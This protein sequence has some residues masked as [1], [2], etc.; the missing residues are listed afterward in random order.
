MAKSFLQLIATAHRHAEAEGAGD[1]DALLAT[2]DAEPI[3]E[4]FPVRR[5]FCGMRQ[6]RRFYEHF[7]AH[8]SRRIRNA[9]LIGQWV[10]PSGVVE[11]YE[12]LIQ[13]ADADETTSHRI[14]ALLKFGS[15]GLAGERMHADEALLRV[16]CGPLWDEL[17]D[18]P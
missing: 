3:Y 5:R 16:L 18:I 17:E 9:E 4:F 15:D 7:I 1:L 14:V 8:V 12:M 2:M 13:A 10:G 6:T 11:E